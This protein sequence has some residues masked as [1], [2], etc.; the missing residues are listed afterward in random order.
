VVS[1]TRQEGFPPA[2][3]PVYTW[4]LQKQDLIIE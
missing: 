4:V 1:C 2:V 3:F